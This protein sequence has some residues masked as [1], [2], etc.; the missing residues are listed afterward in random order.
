M[1]QQYD[2]NLE[3]LPDRESFSR[4]DKKII[5]DAGVVG[6]LMVISR[7]LGFVRDSV[8]AMILGAGIYSDAFFAAFR[9]PDLFRKFFSD[10]ALS[11]FF[12]PV[13]TTILAQKGKKDA[14]D[15]AL[16]ALAF[17]LLSGLLFLFLYFLF[18]ESFFATPDLTIQL[19]N[20]MM[21]YLIF[22]SLMSICMAVLNS[23]GHFA[24]PAFAPVI[25]NITIII[26]ALFIARFSTQPAVVI[27]WGVAIGGFFQLF[28]QIPFMM[29]KGFTFKGRVTLFH[30]D[31]MRTFKIMLPSLV[32]IAPCQINM[33]AATFMASSMTSKFYEGS[34]SYLYYAD[35]LVQF[36]LALF[37]VSV[38]TSIFPLISKSVAMSDI[39]QASALFVKGVRI[40]LF[41]IIPSTAGLIVLREPIVALLFYQGA[42]NIN[43]VYATSW[44]IFCLCG[45][46][47]AFS[48][49]RIIVPI[50]YALSNV[51]IPFVG[52]VVSIISN[53]VLSLVLMDKLG[54]YG[55]SISISC[56]SILNLIFLVK[57]L[58]TVNFALS[59]REIIYTSL[60]SSFFALI[61]YA[62][63]YIAS[64][65]LCPAEIFTDKSR[66]LFG[67]VV[68]IILG[69]SVYAGLGLIFKIPEL[70]FL[71]L[72]NRK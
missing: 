63:V 50:F 55:L 9:I 44:V 40:V 34:V 70:K 54:V 67:V 15:M 18:T 58:S 22:V 51:T 48:G 65:S 53:I 49:L 7:I 10:G 68:S 60:R 3:H 72:F 64:K 17:I 61:M 35:R 39:G 14:F 41:M 5:K 12:I 13:F 56:A 19:T 36:P 52:G 47:W 24:A 38:S 25:L 69:A 30:P 6:T 2:K 31:A 11:I 21:P 26:F 45:G 1:L 23:M 42:F 32:G 20:I 8:A 27:A 66:L 4:S 16:S 59:W 71:K 33:L 28:I 43:D 57:A 62:V 29:K 37:T 46:L